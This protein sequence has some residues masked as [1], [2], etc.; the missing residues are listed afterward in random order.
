MTPAAHPTPD[1]A[2]AVRVGRCSL[3]LAVLLLVAAVV[4]TD[5]GGVVLVLSYG[6]PG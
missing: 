1:S 2:R 3:A 5:A 6:I 4:L